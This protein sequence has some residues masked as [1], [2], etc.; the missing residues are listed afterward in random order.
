VK[1]PA[2]ATN[3]GDLCAVLADSGHR[4]FD[5]HATLPH[6]LSLDHE[7]LSDYY[8]GIECRLTDCHGQVIH[9]VLA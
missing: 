3:R 4:N 2:P 1:R 9:A 5:L 6:L 7:R 8:N